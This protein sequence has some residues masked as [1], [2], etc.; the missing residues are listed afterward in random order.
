[1][2]ASVS[3]LQ[4]RRPATDRPAGAALSDK[5][6]SEAAKRSRQARLPRRPPARAMSPPSTANPAQK[7][8]TG[9][10]IDKVKEVAKSAGD[11]FS[12]VPCLPPKGG[13]KSMGSLP[14]VAASSPRASR[15]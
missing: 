1:M 5:A 8:L 3:P 7:G 2:P 10:A 11:I 14:H 4:R 9:K 13:A 12:R 6:K 15:W